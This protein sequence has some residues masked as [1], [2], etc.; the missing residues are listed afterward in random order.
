MKKLTLIIPCYNEADALPLF[1]A[2]LNKVI[3]QLTNYNTEVLL[4]NDGSSDQTLTVMK[5][6]CASDSHYKYI[7]FSRNFGK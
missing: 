2:E 3:V 1:A 5:E 7:S 6:I 4:V